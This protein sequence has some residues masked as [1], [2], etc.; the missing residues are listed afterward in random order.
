M[1][2]FWISVK[3]E[4]PQPSSSNTTNSATEKHQKHCSEY[5]EGNKTTYNRF[6]M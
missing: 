4:Y 6:T 5:P 3:E 2:K 1:N